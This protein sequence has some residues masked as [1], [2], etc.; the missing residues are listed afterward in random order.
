MVRGAA[1][2]PERVQT[3]VEPMG[4][5]TRRVRFLTGQTPL[6]WADVI[7]AWKEEPAF[8]THF[9]RVL[10]EA[11]QRA[12]F[13]ETP[14]VTP[15]TLT[16]AFECVVVDSPALAGAPADPAPFREH[17]GRAGERSVVTFE[18][19]GGD[20]TLIVPCPQGSETA[21]AHLADF[22]REGPPAQIDAL[23]RE[24]GEQLEARLRRGDAPCWVS[25]SGLGVYWIHVRLDSRPKY[26]THAPYRHAPAHG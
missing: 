21:Y 1:P 11:R 10:A 20:A 16:Q 22:V 23:W 13:W 5:Q 12:F 4:P 17:F 2:D 14:A 24:V 25:T 18:N 15:A 26:Y 6:R 9:T 7:A 19:L 3:D 8:R